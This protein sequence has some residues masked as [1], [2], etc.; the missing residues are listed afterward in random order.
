M[1]AIAVKS[2]EERDDVTWVRAGY[3]ACCHWL[4]WWLTVCM[5]IGF[6]PIIVQAQVGSDTPSWGM[7]FLDGVFPTTNPMNLSDDWAVVPAFPNLPVPLTVTIT[8]NPVNGQIW[9]TS[10]DGLIQAFDNDADVANAQTVLDLRDRVLAPSGNVDGGVFGVALHPE[11]GQPESPFRNYF[12]IYHAS[13]CPL[14][15]ALDTVDLEACDPDYP[16]FTE[17]RQGFYNVYLRLSRFEIPDGA[18]EAD[19]N[20][21]VVLFNLRYI[22]AFHRGGGPIF[23]RDGHLYM[24]M[25]DQSEAAYAQAIHDNLNGGVLRLAVNVIEHDDGTWS[26][27]ANSHIPRRTFQTHIS[28]TSD[29][30]SGR[31]YCIPDDNPWLDATGERHFEEYFAIGLRNPHRITAD[32]LTG[33][34]WVGDVGLRDREE[35]DII[36]KG[37]NY[38]WPFR[39]GFIEGIEPPPETIL[40]IL[41]DPVIDIAH[42]EAKAL[43]GGYVYRG[44][45]FPDLYGKYIAGDN[46]TG[47]IWAFTLDENAMR[48]TKTLLTTWTEGRFG[49]STWGEDLDGE[50]YLGHARLTTPLT[51]L[52]QVMDRT[53]D[54]PPRLSQTGA[55]DQLDRLVP[56]AAWLPYTVIQPFWSDGALMQRWI[57]LP[58]GEQIRFAER[59]NWGYPVGTV[60][61]QHIE[62]PVDETNP[63]VTV[64]LETRFLVHGETGWYGV[65]YRWNDEQ[66][67]AVLLSGPERAVYPVATLDGGRRDAVWTFPARID[68]LTCHNPAAGGALGPRTHQLNAELTYPRSGITDNQLV[69]WNDLGMLTPALDTAAIPGWIRAV[70]QDD[71]LAPLE[72]RARSY[73]DANCAYCHRPET[74]NRALFD[75]RL[76]TPLAAQGLLNGAVVETLGLPDEAVIRPGCTDC[77]VLYQ[78]LAS[79]ETIAMPPLLKNRVDVDGLALI[80]AWIEELGTGG[81]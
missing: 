34:I 46:V 24:A 78:R 76:T 28:G 41:T 59:D 2:H 38:G 32:R 31:L 68:C 16:I 80:Q 71:A 50:L 48:A 9:V 51:T 65:T 6:G 75:A 60:L 69:V 77:S 58:A 10:W 19:R 29:E 67:D 36:E 22:N 15:D 11:F 35:I 5:L 27:P 72:D 17:D 37:R 54:P 64:R 79:L 21:E 40:G 81:P 7:P 66:T 42:P 53:P 26:C 62:L 44:R 74:G 18:T 56:S 45:R 57:A 14:N 4:R 8:H 12:Y 61:M 43:I 33:R 55:F 70:A 25:G 52:S 20:S 30:V 23:G 3:G 73:L 63:T 1:N 47:H 39:E 49:F 13:F